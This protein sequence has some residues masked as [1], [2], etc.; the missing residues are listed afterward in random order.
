M[1]GRSSRTA[2]TCTTRRWKSSPTPASSSSGVMRAPMPTGSGSC[3]RTRICAAASARPRDGARWSSSRPRRLTRRMQDIVP[4][5]P[6]RGGTARAGAGHDTGDEA[7]GAALPGRRAPDGPARRTLTLR[8]RL[9]PLDRHAAV[10]AATGRS[11]AAAAGAHP[12]QRRST[13][14]S[15]LLLRGGDPA[16]AAGRAADPAGPGATR[17]LWWA[18]AAYSPDFVLTLPLT[19]ATLDQGYRRHA[20]VRF[21]PAVRHDR[22]MPAVRD[23]DLD[24]RI[25]GWLGGVGAIAALHA[26][27]V[28]YSENPVSRASHRSHADTARHRGPIANA[29]IIACVAGRQF[30]GA[31]PSSGGRA[32]LRGSALLWL[33][34]LLVLLV[35]ILAAASGSVL[36]GLAAALLASA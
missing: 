13:P 34:P 18:T 35:F 30:P 5:A 28:L 3:A 7:R 21:D 32:P 20:A 11:A 23:P 9:E 8:S 29:N 2:R 1:G 33:A 36:V 10:R 25:F 24:G 17:D 27:I 6:R 16:G 22:D 31:A 4:A 14:L 12:A 26:L 19:G 15:E